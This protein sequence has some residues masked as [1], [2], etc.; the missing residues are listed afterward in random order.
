MNSLEHGTAVG[1]R[2]ETTMRYLRIPLLGLLALAALSLTRSS[3]VDSSTGPGCDFNRDSYDDLAIGAPYEDVGAIQDAGAVNV[4]YGS[5]SGLTDVGDQ[6]WHQGLPGVL[7]GAEADD[8]FGGALACGDYDGDGFD[9]LA[10]G[11]DGEDVGAVQDAGAVNILYG[12]PSGLTDVGDQLWHQGLP[13]VQGHAEDYDYFGWPLSSGDYDGDGFDDLAIGAEAEDVGAVDNAGSVNVLY[14]SPFGLTNVGDQLWHQGLPGVQ[15]G[16]ESSDHFG[17]ALSSGDYD[18]DGFDDLAIGAQREDVGAIQDAGAVNV[19]YGSPFGLTDVGDQLW[20][21]GLPGVLGAAEMGDGFGGALSSGDYDGDGRDDLAIGASGEGVGPIGGAGAVNVL[22][23]SPSGL[24]DVGDQLWHQGLPGVQGHAEA[25]DYFGW[26]L[27][28]GD[29]DGDAHDDL[30]VG[31]PDEDVGTVYN[32]GVVNLL[33][34]S[35]AGLTDVGDQLWH[36][37]LPGVL[38]GAEDYDYFGLSL[39]KR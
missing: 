4:L 12:S 27:S 10:I 30:G 28:S 35:P 9:D 38:G 36:Q 22:Y 3:A 2:R 33:R 18:G 1:T 8:W 34:G 24:T 7:G 25:A 39:G 23:G 21:Q 19:L 16:A 15:G 13:G 14:G 31:A 26:P 29:H 6:L 17:S 5:G 37:G 11:A 20:H 32:A